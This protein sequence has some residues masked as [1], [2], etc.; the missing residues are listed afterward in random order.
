VPVT[1][2]QHSQV[3]CIRFRLPIS[4]GWLE[5]NGQIV[6]VSK[7]K[8]EVGI[9]FVDLQEG[10]RSKLRRWISQQ[11]SQ[12]PFERETEMYGRTGQL[13]SPDSA[14]HLREV[15]LDQDWQPFSNGWRECN[16]RFHGHTIHC[17]PDW[18]EEHF[19]RQ[20]E[21]VRIYSSSA[22]AKS[23]A[24]CRL[25]SPISDSCA[26]WAR[27]SRPNFHFVS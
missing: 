5:L 16:S 6:W 18:M 8:T 10:T 2:T 21:N 19:K 15:R 20:K 22:K 13:S 14:C 23:L 27:L 26:S 3:P 7:S 1:L 17:D 9:K 24:L 4:E 11:P 25:S 12:L